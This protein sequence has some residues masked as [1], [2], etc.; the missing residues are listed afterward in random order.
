M[1]GTVARVEAMFVREVWIG[2]EGDQLEAHLGKIWSAA[3]DL[4]GAHVS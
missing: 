2:W 3:F 1:D 4:A